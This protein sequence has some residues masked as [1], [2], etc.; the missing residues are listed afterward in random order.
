MTVSVGKNIKGTVSVVSSHP[1]CKD[2]NVQFATV[3]LEALSDKFF[4]FMF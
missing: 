4:G 3:P 1:S 2:G